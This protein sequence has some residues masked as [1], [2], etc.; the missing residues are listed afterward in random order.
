M[1][2]PICFLLLMSKLWLG[3][4]G[5][6]SGTFNIS[7]HL[8]HQSNN[9]MRRWK[10]VSNGALKNGLV[11]SLRTHLRLSNLIFHCNKK[12]MLKSLAFLSNQQVRV[13]W[14]MHNINK[15][16]NSLRCFTD[17]FIT[18]DDP[19]GS[20]KTVSDN[21]RKQNVSNGCSIQIVNW[22]V[23]NTRHLKWYTMRCTANQFVSLC[24]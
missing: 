22:P 18:V 12:V 11:I 15:T 6:L 19:G 4:L 8:R 24:F 1:I 20:I 3:H 16:M 10:L 9:C 17:N 7:F 14:Y 2:F 5:Q 13:T 23:S 21:T